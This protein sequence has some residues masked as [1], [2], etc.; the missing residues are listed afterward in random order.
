VTAGRE[1]AEIQRQLSPDFD[2]I[3]RDLTR[4]MAEVRD[5]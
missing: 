2:A 1:M 3:I 5:D 4:D